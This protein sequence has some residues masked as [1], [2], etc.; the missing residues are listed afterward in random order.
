VSGAPS[1]DG[2]KTCLL[3]NFAEVQALLAASGVVA[4]VFS[5]HFHT[6]GFGVD[7]AGVAHVTLES[8][9]THPAREEGGGSGGGDLAHAILHFFE[10]RAELEGFGAVASRTL[11]RQGAKA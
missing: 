5:G 2:I 9:L 10:D 4:G 11:R 7:G 3:F 1:A 8:P 6:G